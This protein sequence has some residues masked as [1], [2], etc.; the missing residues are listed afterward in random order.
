MTSTRITNLKHLIQNHDEGDFLVI[1]VR[2]TDEHAKINASNYI[3]S[4][5]SNN[6]INIPLHLLNLE[7]GNLSKDK[8]LYL[9]CRS[10]GRSGMATELLQSHGYNAI[11]LAGGVISL[12]MK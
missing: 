1:D 5:D 4:L 10:G 2:G 11:N 9:Y 3:E 8:T 12:Q 6:H 7:L